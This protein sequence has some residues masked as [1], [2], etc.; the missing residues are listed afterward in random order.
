MNEQQPKDSQ[1][2]QHG[3]TSG[4]EGTDRQNYEGYLSSQVSDEWMKERVDGKRDEIRQIDQQLADTTALRREAYDRLQDHVMQT[5]LAGKNA[6]L[7]EADIKT[8]EEERTKLKERRENTASEYSLLA[9]LIFVAAGI[10]FVAGDLIISHEIVAYALNIRN[11]VEAW[12]FAVGLAM[13]SILLKPAYDRL[14][15][16]PYNTNA[17]PEAARRYGWF[18]MGL[19]VLSIITLVILGWFRYDAYRTDKLK[20]AINKSIKNIQLNATPLDPTNPNPVTDQRVLQKIEQQLQQSD[21]LNLQLVNSPWALMSFVLSGVL[22]ALA[23]AVCLGIGLPV[24]QKF[25]FRWLQ[26]DPRLWRLRRRRNRLEKKY[27]VAQQEVAKHLT[28]KNIMDHEL[29]VLP[30]LDELRQRKQQLTND[31]DRLIDD[32]K[33]ARTDSRIASFNDG[34]EKGQAARQAMSEE[35]YNQF[36]NGFFSVSNLAT[37]ARSSSDQER[38]ASDKT[39]YA[40]PR[41]IN[42]LRPHQAVRKRFAE[43]L[44]DTNE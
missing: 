29:E 20:E 32:R 9:G 5:T 14:I 43:G 22:F 34:Y 25:W 23:G 10:S 11:N 17:T 41:P 19:A 28:Q 39:N 1:D 37:K 38:L 31:I 40:N 44:D 26:V 8:V 18:K 12:M 3:Y 15:E 36:R 35:E 21:E 2:F 42:G 7:L 4:V 24:L 30:S 13:V 6:E 16:E 27:Q 33:L